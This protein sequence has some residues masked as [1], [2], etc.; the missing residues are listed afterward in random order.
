MLF[1]FG[2]A[3]QEPIVSSQRGVECDT[4][5]FPDNLLDAFETGCIDSNQTEQALSLYRYITT[6]FAAEDRLER[7]DVLLHCNHL[8][9]A[10]KQI[11]KRHV[12]K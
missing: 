6:E 10:A 4:V 7:L 12:A 3:R 9:D 8:S 1:L 5:C 11:L 2:E